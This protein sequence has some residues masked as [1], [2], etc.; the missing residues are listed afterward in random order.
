MP[1]G[2]DVTWRNV[3]QSLARRMRNLRNMTC[4]H[5]TASGPCSAHCMFLVQID[6]VICAAMVDFP[7]AF[8]DETAKRKQNES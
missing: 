5:S 2:K 6:G 8:E 3:A 1:L 7:E 4:N